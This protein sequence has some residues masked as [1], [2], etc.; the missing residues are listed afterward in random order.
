MPQSTE[1]MR[2]DTLLTD[3]SVGYSNPG[4]IADSLFP[5][6]QVMEK[7]GLIPRFKKSHWFRS[8]A[9]ERAPGTKSVGGTW[10]VDSNLPYLVR[11]YSYR[12]EINDDDRANA[13]DVYEL[14][15]TTADFVT[16][17]LLLKREIQWAT[18]FFTTSIWTGDQTGGTDFSQFNNYGSS[19]P[20][21]VL[22]NNMDTVESRIGREPNTFI[23]GKQVWNVLRWHP[24][25]LDAIKYTQV[26][27]MTTGILASMVGLDRIAIGR[28]I[29][30]TSPEGTAE[31]SVTYS[32]VFGKHGL[33]LYVTPRPTLRSPAAGYTFVWNRVPNARQYIKRMRD[34]EREVD[35]IEANGYW[36][37][38]RTAPD[39]GLFLASAV[40]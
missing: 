29:H 2:I 1:N 4:F 27:V 19:S 35:I 38:V 26:G 5:V 22:T 39:A 11:R 28:A 36:D 40:A 10:E 15:A 32:R 9:Q 12:D 17:K 37:M 23:L 3:V 30:T 7:S 33:L 8:D 18:N 34:E 20:L 6:V 31:A 13:A 21:L 25:L 16:E 14:E 24:D